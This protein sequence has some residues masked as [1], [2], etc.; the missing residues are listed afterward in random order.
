MSFDAENLGTPTCDHLGTDYK[1]YAS[2]FSVGLGGIMW[3][4]ATNGVNSTF[5]VMTYL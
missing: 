4:A 1:G 3:F 2:I 5:S